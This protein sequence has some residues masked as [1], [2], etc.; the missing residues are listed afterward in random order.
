MRGGDDHPGAGL[1]HQLL[2]AAMEGFR[3]GTRKLPRRRRETRRVKTSDT[4]EHLILRSGLAPPREQ[5]HFQ[6]FLEKAMDAGLW[7]HHAGSSRR[8]KGRIWRQEQR[9]KGE[10]ENPALT[11]R[12]RGTGLPLFACLFSSWTFPT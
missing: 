8:R 3:E 6:S 4:G 2:L 1:E 11:C 9:H 10:N 7:L 12:R 5:G